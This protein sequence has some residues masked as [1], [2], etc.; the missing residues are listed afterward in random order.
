MMSCNTRIEFLLTVTALTLSSFTS[1]VALSS[2]LYAVLLSKPTLAL[3]EFLLELESIRL[4]A[5]IASLSILL[6]EFDSFLFV[7]GDINSFLFKLFNAT[8]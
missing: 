8:L 7:L 2:F 3:L 5:V 1:S 6:E 4:I